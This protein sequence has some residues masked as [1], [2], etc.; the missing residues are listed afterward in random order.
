MSFFSYLTDRAVEVNSL[1]CVGLDPH[2]ELLHQSTAKDARD[3]CIGLVEAT[4]AHVCAF[5]PNSAFF[6]IYGAQ[7]LQALREVIENVPNGIPV[8]LDAKRGDI[9]SSANAYVQAAFEWLGADAITVSPYLGF[10][11]LEPFLTNPEHGVFLLCKTSNPGAADFQELRI[12][13]DEPLYVHIARQ[14][15]MWNT[16]D[17]LG[18]VV[19]ATD[20]RALAEV[21]AT[22]PDLWLLAPGVGAQR[23]NLEAAIRAGLRSDGLGVVVPVSRGIA[24]AENPRAEAIRL[25]EEINRARQETR[26]AIAVHLILSPLLAELAD[27]LLSIGCVRFGEF[28]LKSGVTSPI[29]ID[30]RILSSK[31]GLLSR[32]AKTYLPL[33]DDLEYDRLAALPYAALPITTA[34]SLQSGRPMVYPRKEIKDYGTQATVEGGFREGETVVVIDDLVT[35]G[36]S[37]LEAISRLEAVGLNVRDIVVLIDRQGGAPQTLSEAGY[38]LHAVYTL[39]DLVK[40][41]EEMGGINKEQ[42]DAVRRLIGIRD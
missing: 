40:H 33:L 13:E 16:S 37:K 42:A 30:L 9:A 3:F 7:G 21:R 8:I 2:P 18:L 32:V 25:R 10:D 39:T 14:A 1:L 20:P 26:E 27:E 19:G 11:S 34:I 28:T 41:W 6:E 4:S 31:P 17:N 15:S 36:G 5:K 23:A 35:T 38:Q 22:V 12:G 24:R 29:Y